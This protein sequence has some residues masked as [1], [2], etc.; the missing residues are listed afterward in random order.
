MRTRTIVAAACLLGGAPSALA[1]P[2]PLQLT[3]FGPSSASSWLA[4][5]VAGYN[6]QRGAVVF[7]FEGDLSG[8][9]LKSETTGGY[10]SANPAFSYPSADAVAK[11]DWYGTVRAR[12]GWATGAFLIYGTAGLAY[13]H[14]ALSNTYNLGTF[15][16]LQSIGP[17]VG[18]A[19]PVK[20]GWVVGGGVEYLLTRD[21][22]L[23]L[24]YQYVDLGS[25]GVGAMTPP[26]PFERLVGPSASAH[27]QFQA[28]TL[29]VNWHFAPPDTTVASVRTR[30]GAPVSQPLS[31]P[32]EGLYVGGRAGGD[33]GDRL[34][35][36][37]PARIL[38]PT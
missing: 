15:G 9:E 26:A 16:Q 10:V 28:V 37:P 1:G 36:T 11:I 31:N 4:G 7:G 12:L 30:R 32:W 13:G 5:A 18:Q 14:A 21:V 24:E 22:S 38:P 6:W 8:T 35:V 27:A 34:S 23:N 3:G 17:L 20:A 19:S 29:G 33:W 2:P 25:V